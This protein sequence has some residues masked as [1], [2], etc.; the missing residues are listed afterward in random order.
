MSVRQIPVFSSYEEKVQYGL[1]IVEENAPFFEALAQMNPKYKGIWESGDRH[2]LALLGFIFENTLGRITEVTKIPPESVRKALLEGKGILAEATTL[3]DIA[4]YDIN[5]LGVVSFLFPTLVASDVVNIQPLEGPTGVIFYKRY[6][7]E[8]AKGKIAAGTELTRSDQA[9]RGAA[10]QGIAGDLVV[11]EKI[12]AGNGTNTNF[13]GTLAWTPVVPT[14]VTVTDGT[15]IVTDDGN[16]G[17]TGDGNGTINY[18]T[19]SIAVTFNSA[20]ASGVDVTVTYRFENHGNRFMTVKMKLERKTVSA[21]SR[22]LG[23]RWEAEAQQDLL[24]YHQIAIEDDVATTLVE[25]VA[26]EIDSKVLSDLYALANA[27]V[28]KEIWDSTPPAGTDPVLYRQTIAFAIR[29]VYTKI[30]DAIGRRP[31]NAVA[32]AVCGADAW[33]YV[34]TS[35]KLKD[36]KLDGDINVYYSP[37]VP[38]NSIIVGI[39]GAD[40]VTGGYVYSPY[41]L[42]VS[43]AVPSVVNGETHPFLYT[44]GILSRDAFTVINPKFYGLVT[45]A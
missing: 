19:G 34:Q 8:Q 12:G 44:K 45:V 22:V 1:S 2:K 40:A 26:T 6:L 43:P 42:E 32:F 21:Q 31:A 17:L 29:K 15:Q 11:D 23:F 39:K 9:D 27:G 3:N 16:G 28:Y 25:E 36:G 13:N 35:G 33:H 14:T 37:L 30:V 24:A 20:P 5:Y 18:E 4:G 10:E 38:A 41:R 7:T